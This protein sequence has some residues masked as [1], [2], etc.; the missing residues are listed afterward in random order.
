M[1][2]AV[3]VIAILG[4]GEAES[5]CQQV[6]LAGPRYESAAACH[7]A[8]TEAIEQHQEIAFPV[9]V[10]E[11]RAANAEA[12]SELMPKDVQLPEAGEQPAQFQRATYNSEKPLRT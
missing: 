12:T 10:A 11:C 7:A 2:P 3:F 8:T 9:V 5:P 6:A 1:G 4:C